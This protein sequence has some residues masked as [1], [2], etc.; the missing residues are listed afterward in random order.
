MVSTAPGEGN[1]PPPALSDTLSHLQ[2]D[3]E[4]GLSA[5]EALK[6]SA[7]DGPNDLPEKPR[8][9]LRQFLSKFWNLSAWMIELIAVLSFLIH[10]PL[11]MG[12]AL[13]LLV[14]NAILSYRQEQRATAAVAALR[15]R[16]QVMARVRRDGAWITLSARDLVAGDILRVRAGDFVPADL[17]VMEGILQA[18]Q[19]T[20]TGESRAVEKSPGALLYSGSVLHSGEATAVVTATGVRTWYGKTAQLVESAHPKLHVEAV[21]AQVVR[22]L[23]ALVAVLVGIVLLSALLRQQPLL[24]LLPV[25]LAVLM[26]AVPVALPVMFTVSMALGSLELAGKGVLITQLSAIEDAATMDVLCADKTGTLTA[27]RLTVSGITPFS[28]W[29]REQL[30]QAGVWASNTANNDPID[31]AFLGAAQAQDIPMPAA[32]VRSFL[33]FS[34][35]TRRT[36]S[37]VEVAGKQLRC[38]K[39]AWRTIGELAALPQEQL[40]ALERQAD[41]GAARGMRTLAVAC[42]ENDGPVQLMGVVFLRDAPRPDS[43]G[44]IGR[45]QALGVRIK[46]LTG[47]ALPVATEVAREL[48]L[49]NIVQATALHSA[50]SRSDAEGRALA[51]SADGFA[52]VFP[53]DKF[54]VVQQLQSGGH[55]VGMTGDGVNDAPALRQAEVGIAVSA[56][57][58]VA[59]GA[60]SAVLTAEGLVNIVDL[61]QTGRAIYQRVLTWILYKVSQTLLKAGFVVLS[62]LVLGK[63]AISLLGIVLLVFLND[64]MMISLAT[65]RVR[66]SPQPETWNITP[67]LRVAAILGVLMLVEALGLLAFGYERLGLDNSPGLLLTYGFEILASFAMFA[68]FSLRERR[69]FWHSRPSTVLLWV[70][71]LDG[72]LAAALGMTG[73]AEMQAL[74]GWDVLLIFV[75]A[76]ACTFGPNDALKTVLMAR[77]LPS[78]RPDMGNQS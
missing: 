53:E 36:E 1:Q 72:I 63:F 47:D 41:E 74:P 68:V 46:M 22:W 33:P 25:A 31:L 29:S 17:Q 62:Y 24:H 77:A 61:V 76:G 49:G 43:V 11:D 55:I 27:N 39:G 69:S 58:D 42:A 34:A 13:A 28:P 5:S 57:T 21:I 19:S 2:V 59:K 64:F 3:P 38:L 40:A 6:R 20:L 15:Q 8:H 75:V 35:A 60:A 23:L 44:L 12:I 7:R 14:V 4:T 18:D 54:Q 71:L 51:E 48:Q 10:K 65:D 66:T 56:A 78:G 32:Q 9:R 37:V 73:V 30:L 26:N 52:E 70:V 16:L 50:F 45:L 67:Q